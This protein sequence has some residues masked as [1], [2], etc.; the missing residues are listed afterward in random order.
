MLI[1]VDMAPYA[2]NEKVDY[3]DGTMGT[4]VWGEDAPE[5]ESTREAFNNRHYEVDPEVAPVLAPNYEQ[6]LGVLRWAA[7]NSKGEDRARYTDFLKSA[8]SEI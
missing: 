6:N 8:L 7:K 3:P 5:G 1:A 4:L 2:E